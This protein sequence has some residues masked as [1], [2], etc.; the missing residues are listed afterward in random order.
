[1]AFALIGAS[2]TDIALLNAENELP[3][4]SI[5]IDDSKTSPS[6]LWTSDYISKYFIPISFA[7]RM[8]MPQCAPGPWYPFYMTTLKPE[9]QALY[10]TP[11][12][13]AFQCTRSGL[14]LFTLA[15]I[16][17][18]KAKIS[19]LSIDLEGASPPTIVGIN[20]NNASYYNTVTCQRVMQLNVGQRVQ[21]RFSVSSCNTLRPLTSFS[22]KHLQ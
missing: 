13:T 18:N 14:Y 2:M 11:D 6:N 8:A 3:A 7:G 1:M 16:E 9:H 5:T 12:K 4:N 20:S 21:F 10:I 19:L 22:I 17:I 15:L